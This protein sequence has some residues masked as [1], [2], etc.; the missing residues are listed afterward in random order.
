MN[1]IKIDWNSMAKAYEEFNNAEDSYSFNIEWPCIKDLL[2]DLRGKTIVDLG[3]GTGIFTF[4]LEKSD[5]SKL[6]GIDLSEEMLQI[7]RDKA[8]VSNSKAEFILHDAATCKEV[9]EEPVDFI[10][11][12]TTSHY[13]EN[14]GHLFENVAKSLKDGGECV[15][16]IIHPVYSA[17]YP[18]EHADGS[19]PEDEEW[20]VRYL[21]KSMR[22]Y[23]QPWLEYNDVYENHLS[24]SYHHT[25]SDYMNAI[26]AAGL[27]I[28]QVCE[29][30]APEDW[31]ETQPYRYEGFLET[32]VYM[33]IKMRKN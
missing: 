33:I 6:I 27:S 10:F 25:M 23:I 28:E 30:M 5:P 8:K 18:V 26:I 1:E 31:K 11:S 17:M 14:L 2:P 20:N 22:S 9:I 21:D 29:P 15:F 13:I 32:P 19:F 4:L 24:K 3:C 7:A 12:S 16:S